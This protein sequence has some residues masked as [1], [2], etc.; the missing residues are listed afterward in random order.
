MLA[1]HGIDR[2]QFTV[3][4]PHSMCLY[5]VPPC[6]ASN[7][8]VT[9]FGDRL[10]TCAFVKWAKWKAI[11]PLYSHIVSLC[12]V[13][14]WAELHIL[15]GF[16]WNHTKS[17][18]LVQYEGHLLT[19][20]FNYETIF[21]RNNWHTSVSVLLHDTNIVASSTKLNVT[22]RLFRGLTVATLQCW[23]N[24]AWFARLW[25]SFELQRGP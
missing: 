19:V 12:R 10:F 5:S 22:T 6:F 25:L 23:D 15:G 2:R 17:L 7:Y 20:P 3:H 8:H 16:R 13:R 18:A 21:N 14:N 4:Y 11:L 24:T 1:A 9:Y